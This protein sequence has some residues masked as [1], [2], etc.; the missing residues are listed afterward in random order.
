[1]TY[2]Y[3]EHFRTSN[4][5]VTSIPTTRIP[6][7]PPMTRATSSSESEKDKRRRDAFYNQYNQ[8]KIAFVA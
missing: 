4:I 1:M 8:Y 7:M 3:G 5:I 2:M 6:K